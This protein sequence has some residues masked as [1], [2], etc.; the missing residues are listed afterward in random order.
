MVRTGRVAVWLM[1]AGLAL[2]LPSRSFLGF[3]DELVSFG[4]LALGVADAVVNNRWRAYT[5]LWIVFGVM[6]FYTAY[7]LVAVDYNTPGA[8]L[9]GAVIEGKPFYP[10]AVMYAV[11]PS[12]TR[13]EC[14]LLCIISYVNVAL[15]AVLTAMP[16]H[17]AEKIIP[18]ISD[19]NIAV[20]VSCMMLTYCEAELHHGQLPLS[21]KLII[22]GCMA[23]G[24]TTLKAK[25]MGEFVIAVFLFFMYR[26]GMFRHIRASQLLTLGTVVALTIAVAWNKITYYFFHDGVE[27]LMLESEDSVARAVMYGVSPIILGDHLLF[28]SGLASFA[29]AASVEPYSQLYPEYGLDLV[30]G[31]SPE[32]SDFICDAYYPSLVQFGLVGIILF[33][34]LWVWVYRRLLGYLRRPVP[35]KWPFV[36]GLMGIV[37]ILIESV[38]ATTLTQAAGMA[39]MAL[40]GLL[41]AHSTGPAPDANTIVKTSNRQ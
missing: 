23:I 37:F 5:L 32:M 6:L 39:A 31:L 10:L 24:L 40:L 14:K 4:F 19:V 35:L 25:F 36:A 11:R 20:M 1:I 29:S 8:V 33:I 21:R 17:L 3:A 22:L 2:I 12:L 34:M 15:G 41:V 27:S 13:A 30:W 18:H 26:P 28:G 38:A 7:S 16:I 9:R